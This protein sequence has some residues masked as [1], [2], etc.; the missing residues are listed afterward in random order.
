MVFG[1]SSRLNSFKPI[2]IKKRL[3]SKSLLEKFAQSSL[4][5]F[6][7]PVKDLIL[8]IYFQLKRYPL[9]SRCIHQ[10][11]LTSV[12]HEKYSFFT[13]S[14]IA[15]FFIVIASLR[16]SATFY[17]SSILFWLL[18]VKLAKYFS[19]RGSL[20]IGSNSIKCWML[21]LI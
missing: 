18:L 17:S 20:L 19:P 1:V 7:A 2:R 3:G 16:N 5:Y 12:A 13:F 6:F 15:F 9:M 14:I 11:P 10:N 4:S 8:Q 21:L